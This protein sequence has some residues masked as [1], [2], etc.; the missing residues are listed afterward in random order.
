ML[1]EYRLL[2]ADV[3]QRCSDV[4]NRYAEQIVCAKGC[5]G[6]CCRIHLSIS[7][8]EAFHLASALSTYPE[9]SVRKIRTAAG[10]ASSAGPCPL[11]VQGACHM[12][13]DRLILC[14]T[15]G[16]PM[17]IHYRG[18]KSV[19]CCQKNFRRLPVIPDEACIDLDRLNTRLAAVNKR[20]LS[21]YGGR[22]ALKERYLIGEALLLEF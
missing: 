18:R 13:S 21:E 2:A 8:I 5:K 20:F 11:L 19:G 1:E 12:Y 4:Q 6:N 22:F 10:Q 14:R 16:L 3:E 7:A 15:H 9:D 17:L